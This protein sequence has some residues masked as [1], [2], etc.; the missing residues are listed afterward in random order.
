VAP[1]RAAACAGSP[2]FKIDPYR[3]HWRE[4]NENAAIAQ[5]MTRN[6]MAASAHRN[7][8]ISIAGK[9]QH[10]EDIG[11][12]GAT[13][14]QRRTSADCTIPDRADLLIALV[15]RAEQWSA[16]ARSELLH[17]GVR[18]MKVSNHDYGDKEF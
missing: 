17:F 9:S 18:E 7:L 5:G 10:G 15:E 11:C 4:I 12:A 8:Q 2:S 1:Q 13:G 16:E 14:D 3:H 6:R